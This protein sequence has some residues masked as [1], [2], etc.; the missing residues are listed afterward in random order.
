MILPQASNPLI[1]YCRCESCD[2]CGDTGPHPVWGSGSDDARILIVGEAPG[3]DEVIKGRP[4]TGRAGQL[5]DLTLRAAGLTR[6]DVYVTN[7]VVCHPFKNKTPSATAIHACNERLQQDILQ[8]TSRH[9]I[10]CL[11]NSAVRSVLGKVQP[12]GRLNGQVQWSEEFQ[13][14]IAFCYHPAAVLRNPD[15][16]RD[17]MWAFGR[18]M[19]CLDIPKGPIDRP[20]TT[21]YTEQTLEGA[22]HNLED[23]HR[24]ALVKPDHTIACDLETEGLDWQSQKI[25]E[26]GFCIKPGFTYILPQELIY[27]WGVVDK[28]RNLFHDYRLKW[29]WHNGKF[30]VIWIRQQLRIWARI[31]ADTMLMHYMSDE[32]S[33]GEEGGFHDLKSVAMKYCGAPSWADDI[34]QYLPNK[35][36]PFSAIPEDVRHQYHAYDVDYTLRLYYELIKELD[37]EQESFPPRHEGYHEPRWAHDN[38]LVPLANTLADVEA[39]GVPIDIDKLNEFDN[40]WSAKIRDYTQQVQWYGLHV[41]AARGSDGIPMIAAPDWTINVRSPKQLIHILYDVLCLPEYYDPRQ[42]KSLRTTKTDALRGFITLVGQQPEDYPIYTLEFLNALKNYRQIAH[43]HKVY[44]QGF[45]K[46]L[47]QENHLHTTFKIHGTATGRLASANPNLQNIPRDSLIK[48]LFIAEPGYTFFEAD[49]EQ[50]EV[51]V[52]AWYS[53]DPQLIHDIRQDDLHWAMAHRIFP[54]IIMDLEEAKGNPTKLRQVAGRYQVLST[55]A[56]RMDQATPEEVNDPD[57]LYDWIKKR[58]RFQTKFVTFGILYGRG[59]ETLASPI[60]GL[61]VSVAEAARYL[62]DFNKTYNVLYRWRM[63]TINETF[64]NGFVETP[65]GRRRRYPYIEDSWRHVVKTQSA[66]FPVQSFASDLTQASLLKLDKQF[67]ASDLGRVLF[68]VHDSIAGQIRT[69]RLE[70]GMQLVQHTMEHILEDREIEF[71]AEVKSGRSWAECH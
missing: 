1:N 59:S 67:L 2:L 65:N 7:S 33:G 48:Y 35:A 3:E 56:I 31:D 50:L 17:Y 68:T 62:A 4:F 8:H 28:L 12:I 57:L 34:K 45:R 40:D 20:V 15:L 52:A 5:L 6:D 44:I 63:K 64:R 29:I 36:T 43:Q 55:V 25:L 41:R 39:G 19:D 24:S 49:Y 32:R 26:I 11:G 18:M 53:R 58:L 70:E 42:R 10:L 13:C 27:E 14:F 61:G 47:D 37:D 21:F 9:I 22:I 60:D 69:E 38:I 66:N 46:R 51:R 23:L 71:R 16:L 30:D 54:Y